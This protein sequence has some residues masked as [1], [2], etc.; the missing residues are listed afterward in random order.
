MPTGKFVSHPAYT[1][2]FKLIKRTHSE[3]SQFCFFPIPITKMGIV[4]TVPPND[5]QIS[6]TFNLPEFIR[7]ILAVPNKIFKKKK[8][9]RIRWV[10]LTNIG[11]K[12]KRK[13]FWCRIIMFRQNLTKADEEPSRLSERKD[14]KQPSMVLSWMD[15]KME[16]ICCNTSSIELVCWRYTLSVWYVHT[17]HRLSQNRFDRAILTWSNEIGSW[18]DSIGKAPISIA[19]LDFFIIISSLELENM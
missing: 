8:K 18:Q 3:Y 2:I 4:K 7:T 16:W 11:S 15:V 19:I 5:D 1:S 13:C 6:Y 10:D 17:T 14:V 12:T 9:A